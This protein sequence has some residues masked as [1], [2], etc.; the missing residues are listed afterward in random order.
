MD[1]KWFIINFVV[2]MIVFV[3][4]TIVVI[5]RTLFSSTDSALKKL[6]SELAKAN[7]RQAELTRKLK[8]ADEELHKRRR[9]ATELADRM[10]NEAEEESKNEKE[11]IISKAREESEEIIAKAQNSKEKMKIDLEKE[12][13][14]KVIKLSVK[15]LNDVLSKTAHET[16]NRV[17][18]E[19]FLGKLEDVD[20]SRIS[21][22]IKEAQL[23]SLVPVKDDLKE[24]FAKVI[25]R[26]LG[27]K[28][29]V[30]TS[31]DEN[32]GGGVILK[33]GSMALD[34]SLQNLIREAGVKLQEEV[35]VR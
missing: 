3:G 4:V 23:I 9:E 26:K 32:I 1:W 31:V 12:I 21:P 17:L 20:M 28:L 24:K 6:D 34:G 33:F 30:Q 13:D 8:D 27:R 2:L 19:E 11:K 25:E 16:F 5:K 15:V 29:P 7:A 18:A 14:T 35:D 22:E 10:R